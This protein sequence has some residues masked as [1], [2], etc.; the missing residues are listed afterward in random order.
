MSTK[1]KKKLKEGITTGTCAAAAA[2]AA[3]EAF[4][5]KV[6]P[7]IT[8]NLPDD[9]G[10]ISVD[11]HSTKPVHASRKIK[12]ATATVVKDA[13]DDPDITNGALISARVSIAEN[14]I[15]Q[16]TI[17]G[18]AGVGRVTRAG[19][20]V[21]IG[22][23]AIN[24]VPRIMIEQ[25]VKKRLP[26][27]KKFLVDVVISVKDGEKLAQKTLNPRL[28]IIGGI[29]IL[30]THGIVKPFSAKSYQE[31]ID[32]CLRSAQT[33]DQ[34]TCVL[35]TG[36]RSERLAQAYYPDLDEKCFVQM[37]DFFSH[38]LKTANDLG[39]SHI[40]LAGFFG[41][42]CKWAMNMKYTHARSGQTDFGFLSMLASEI[43]LSD[44]FC[45]FVKEANNARHIFESG[46]PDVPI[47]ID[48][49]GQRALINAEKIVKD[50]ARVTLC[51]WD[52]NEKFYQEW[53]T[54]DS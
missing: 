19:L 29:S 18:G 43:G 2:A 17:K 34:K 47:F 4:F 51:L 35:S 53:E 42:L 21:S 26:K 10:I 44:T 14:D 22:E 16:V 15:T 36:R 32:I 5:G 50:K 25:E 38:A 49:I 27:G 1:E 54:A 9:S 41:K 28:G 3:V 31:T 7:N 37:A 39:F 11:I 33:D 13:G 45:R 24:P 20:P 30:G 6:L 8:V 46:H 12:T 23:S 48:T 52:F 40:V